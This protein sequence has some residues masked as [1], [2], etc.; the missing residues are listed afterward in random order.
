MNPKTNLHKELSGFL[1]AGE[2][3]SIALAS[4][5]KS[6][7]IIDELKGRKAAKKLG[8]SVAGSLGILVAAKRRGYI[9]EVK[10]LIEK[11]QKT[12]FRISKKLVDRILEKVNEI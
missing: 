11:I 12:N 10:P 1:D 5:H 9:K 2:A 4:E 8:I 3:T 6:L 7:L